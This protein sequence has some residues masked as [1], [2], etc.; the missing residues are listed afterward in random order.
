MKKLLLFAAVLGCASLSAQTPTGGRSCGTPVLPQQYET[1][2]NSLPGQATNNG[3]P[4]GGG[5]TT[6]QSIFNIP[7][8]VHIIHNNE[9]VNSNTAT[10]GNNISALQVIDQINILNKDY[11]GV[12]ADTTLIPAV[13]KPMFGKFQV[14]FCLAVVNPTGGVLAEPGIDRINRVAKGWNALPYSQ[15]YIDATVKPNSIWDPNRY[16]NI[17]ICPLSGGLLGY[18]T[19]PNPGTSGL[20]GL[21]GT[22]GTARF[23]QIWDTAAVLVLFR[24]LL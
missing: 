9:N 13:F 4:K 1:W 7:V 11:N 18:A 2:V 20:G 17:W 3:G 21:T 23:P 15:T 22:F 6:T 5:G 24:S 10:T 16:L 12:N 19:F 14:N 8:I